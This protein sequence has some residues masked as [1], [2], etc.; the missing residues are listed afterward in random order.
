M[1]DAA[2]VEKRLEQISQQAKSPIQTTATGISRTSVIT[3]SESDTAA[4]KPSLKHSKALP[5][6]KA[7]P[8]LKE[9]CVAPGASTDKHTKLFAF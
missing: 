9:T 7:S 2:S 3:S 6:P 4:V 5:A 1:K 8:S